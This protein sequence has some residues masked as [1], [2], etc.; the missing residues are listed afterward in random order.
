VVRALIDSVRRGD[1][2]RR[3]QGSAWFLRGVR[4]GG[5]LDPDHVRPAS[6][7]V[8]GMSVALWVVTA[9]S[10]TNKGFGP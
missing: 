8:P 4:V 3:I 2:Y 10:C 5:G 6:T 7:W 1:G 9:T